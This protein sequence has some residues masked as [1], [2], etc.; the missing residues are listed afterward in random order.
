M[1]KYS[2]IIVFYFNAQLI[3]AQN[4][5]QQ[6][7]VPQSYFVTY[8]RAE[9]MQKL[10]ALPCGVKETDNLAAII[11]K[12]DTF[13]NSYIALAGYT[14]DDYAKAS[15]LQA[16]KSIKEGG[17][18]IGAV[19]IDSSGQI[20]EAAHNKQIQLHRSDLHG[21]MSLLTQFEEKPS[22]AQYMNSYIYKSGLTVFSSAE[23]CPMCTAAIYWANLKNIYYCNTEKDA[24]EYG[25]IDKEIL[26]ELKKPSD[27]RSI[28]STKIVNPAALRVFDKALKTHL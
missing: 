11:G 24:L 9:Y 18:G 3:T 17:Y 27:K 21:E 26:A 25:F 13:L 1:K 10:A 7:T 8:S 20:I 16:L 6:D 14:D 19:L 5:M 28:K 22:S 15:S 2:L 12:I 4:K 23:P